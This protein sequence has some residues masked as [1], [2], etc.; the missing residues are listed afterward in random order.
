[1]RA[2]D[3]DTNGPFSHLCQS[4]VNTGGALNGSTGSVST[5]IQEPI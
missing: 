5:G 1:M 4:R 2:T 3:A